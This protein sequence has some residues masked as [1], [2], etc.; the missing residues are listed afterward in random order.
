MAAAPLVLVPGYWLGGWA[1]ERVTP[2]LEAAG[3][4]VTALTL[5]GLDPGDPDRS[6]ATLEGHVAAVAEAVRAAGPTTVLV[7][8]SGAGK[9]VT[10]VLDRDPAAVARVVYVDSGPAADGLADAVPADVTELPLPPWVELEASLDGLSDA[11]LATFRRRAVPHPAAVAREPVR[12]TDPARRTVPATLVACSFPAATILELAAGG[13]PMFAEVA[14]LT[15]LTT[16]DLPTGHW[17][18]W[19]RPAEL[20]AVLGRAAGGGH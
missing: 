5:P 8:H 14:E 3:H 10:A 19:S 16:V 9:V 7:A 15:D 13:H 11:D 4:P 2:L 17:P 1:W 12:L 20:A 6:R 18:L